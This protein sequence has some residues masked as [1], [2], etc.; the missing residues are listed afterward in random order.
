MAFVKLTALHRRSARVPYTAIDWRV[1]AIET[2]LCQWC[3]RPVVFH[4][5]HA[6]ECPRCGYWFD[7]HVCGAPVMDRE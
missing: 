6:A 5:A 1:D 4:D 2:G 3:Y 7:G